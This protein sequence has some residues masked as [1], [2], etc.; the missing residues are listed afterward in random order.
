MGGVALPASIPKGL[1]SIDRNL[2]REATKNFP[3][4][5][6][7]AAETKAEKDFVMKMLSQALSSPRDGPV[8]DVLAELV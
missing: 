5:R 3:Q 8:R 6:L 4:G 1:L 7:R 2:R